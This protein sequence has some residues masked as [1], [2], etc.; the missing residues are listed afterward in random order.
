MLH[1]LEHIV[2][3]CKTSRA[4]KVGTWEALTSV[5]RLMCRNMAFQV[6]VEIE[7]SGASFNGAVISS[8]VLAID[9]VATID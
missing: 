7:S 2:L 3:P 9:M 4:G 8:L 1:M 5:R 6:Q